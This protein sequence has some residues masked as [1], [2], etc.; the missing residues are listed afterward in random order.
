MQSPG[1]EGCAAVTKRN[2]ACDYREFPVEMF[3]IWFG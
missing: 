3:T 2:V 1:E